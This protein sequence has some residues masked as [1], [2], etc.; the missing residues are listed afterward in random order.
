LIRK[1]DHDIQLMITD[2]VMPGMSGRELA[3]KITAL[4]R[5]IKVLYISG[6]TD[7]A[8][9]QHGMLKSGIKYLPKPFNILELVTKVRQVLDD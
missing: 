9:V 6:Y 3:E 2:V 1:N 8:I 7:N 4:L 5:D